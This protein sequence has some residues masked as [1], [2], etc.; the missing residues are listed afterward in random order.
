MPA[1]QRIR[2]DEWL[3]NNVDRFSNSLANIVINDGQKEI[4]IGQ[5]WLA[6]P[7]YFVT[8]GHV[9][10]KFVGNF[11]NLSLRFPASGNVYPVSQLRL[12]P[13]F[14]R[15]PDQLVKFDLALLEVNLGLP[16]SEARPLPFSFER[17]LTTNQALY[18]IR[19]PA[20]LGQLSAAIEPL[21]Q[22]GHFLGLLR[23][24]DNFHL[25]HDLPLSPGDSGAPISDGTLIVAVHC[26]D[27]ATLPGLNLPTTSIRLAL[28]VD[29][30]RDLGISQTINAVAAK[31]KAQL[32]PALLAFLIGFLLILGIAYQIKSQEISN[33]WSINQPQVLPVRMTLNEPI[34]GYK[35]GEDIS[36]NL[37]PGS[38]CHV[39]LFQI[40]NKDDNNLSPEDVYIL[41]P[42]FGMSS[43]LKKGES[44]T[45]NYLGSTKIC[46]T[47]DRFPCHLVAVDG[48]SPKGNDIAK[49]LLT[50]ND[51]PK[52][53]RDGHTL[54]S[55]S[56]RE[57]RPLLIKG[58]ALLTRLKKLEAS[59][60]ELITHSVFD[61]AT[62][63]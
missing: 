5:A 44:R 18:A 35:T 14:V 28:W 34:H 47:P 15:Q 40:G 16:E 58:S 6:A 36:I 49:S 59:S 7:S 57:G 41:Y 13:S 46:A 51:W 50:E 11:A 63:K 48:N 43:F 42:Q 22:E 23:K 33:K 25:L 39:F 54:L 21:T 19:Y 12:H 2:S 56:D 32:L 4:V 3:I 1:N 62:S 53:D 45:I 30:L 38:N 24:H 31:N 26:G 55:V 60:P 27:T 17:E 20:H 10:E 29:A 9:V 61:S 37:V 52:F 8:C